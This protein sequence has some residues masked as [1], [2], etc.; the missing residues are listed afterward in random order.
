N[1]PK[2]SSGLFYAVQTLLYN[3]PI[4]FFRVVEEGFSLEDYL[5]GLR[6]IYTANSIDAI[7]M[8]GMVES[9]ILDALTP[10][11]ILH[12]QILLFTEKD[13]YDYITALR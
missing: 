13:I 5:I 12:H 4:L 9:D 1:P 7:G 2:Y 11:L 8:P 3:K 10:K 6:M